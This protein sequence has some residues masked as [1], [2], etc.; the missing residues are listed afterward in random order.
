MTDPNPMQVV[1]REVLAEA[2]FPK[3]LP[4]KRIVVD[5]DYADAV[6]AQDDF[7]YRWHVSEQLRKAGVP[8]QPADG[9]ISRGQIVFFDLNDCN[10]RRFVWED[11]SAPA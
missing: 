1:A 5:V 3:A 9:L 7:S 8:I 4:L 6:R 2:L 10:K 11:V